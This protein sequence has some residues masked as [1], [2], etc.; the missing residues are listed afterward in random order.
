MWWEWVRLYFAESIRYNLGALCFYQPPKEET[1]HIAR[2]T[3][4]LI[5]RPNG[6]DAPWEIIDGYEFEPI[7]FFDTYTEA[8]SFAVDMAR[9]SAF[10]VGYSHGVDQPIRPLYN[11]RKKH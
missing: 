5:I 6:I 1:L 3:Y 4:D 11:F 9:R 7:T 10:L 2:V 8:T